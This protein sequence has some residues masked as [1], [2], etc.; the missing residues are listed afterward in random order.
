M[1]NFKIYFVVFLLTT[2]LITHSCSDNLDSQSYVLEISQKDKDDLDKLVIDFNND[3]FSQFG[4][5]IEDVKKAFRSK[6]KVKFKELNSSDGTLLNISL[7]NT[8]EE[9]S[10]ENFASVKFTIAL[11]HVFR[12]PNDIEMAD[13]YFLG[14]N[15]VILDNSTGSNFNFHVPLADEQNRVSFISPIEIKY[16]ALEK[17]QNFES[18]NM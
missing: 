3:L 16:L 6:G 17:Y 9:D 18:I 15:L 5:V 11:D 2:I 1:Q 7:S 8:D 12:T 13:V 10:Y 14:Q 4:L